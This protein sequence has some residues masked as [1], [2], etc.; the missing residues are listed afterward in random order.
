LPCTVIVGG[1]FGDEGKGKIAAYLAIKDKPDICV[2]GGNGPNAGHTVIHGGVPYSLSTRLSYSKSSGK[3][4]P[5]AGSKL[6]ISA[7]SLSR[8]TK[9]RNH[10]QTIFQRKLA[11]LRV[12]LGLVMQN[13]P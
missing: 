9:S 8:A 7:P 1:F 13:E 5:N 4:T 10:D 12:E 11:L 2:R 3:P 6:T